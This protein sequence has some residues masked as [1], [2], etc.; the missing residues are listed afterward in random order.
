MGGVRACE[1]MRLVLAMF[2]GITLP[3]SLAIPEV[4]KLF[5][6]KDKLTEEAGKQ[7]NSRVARLV[8]HM[9][10]YAEAIANQKAAKGLPQ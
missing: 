6:D 1:A 3:Y 2:N 8:N 10:W 5:D 4:Q 7:W 9:Q